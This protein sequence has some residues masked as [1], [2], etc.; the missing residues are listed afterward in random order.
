[1]DYSTVGAYG[2]VYANN[3]C[4]MHGR[5][6]HAWCDGTSGCVL[7]DFR[8]ICPKTTPNLANTSN[9]A[10]PTTSNNTY[11]APHASAGWSRNDASSCWL[12]ISDV[13]S[14]GAE[15]NS[16]LVD[17]SQLSDAD[18]VAKARALIWTA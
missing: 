2:E 13:Q 17:T 16:A 3:T 7:L 14:R 9:L 6:G 11:Y 4:I 8:S 15:L 12:S 10:F 5:T 18:I 1:L